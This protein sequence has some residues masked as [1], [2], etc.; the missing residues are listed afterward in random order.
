M[1]NL[2]IQLFQFQLAYPRINRSSGSAKMLHHV[3]NI[4]SF[5]IHGSQFLIKFICQ[6]QIGAF[7][8]LPDLLK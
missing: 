8:R 6:G 3:A 1:Q 2:P 4:H 7:V 5:A